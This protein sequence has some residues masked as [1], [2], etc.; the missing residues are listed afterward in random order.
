M[1][2]EIRPCVEWLLSRSSKAF[3]Y[4]VSC[5]PVVVKPQKKKR[6]KRVIKNENKAG[7]ET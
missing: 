1:N 3:E 6:I 5:G 2:I 4:K 7:I